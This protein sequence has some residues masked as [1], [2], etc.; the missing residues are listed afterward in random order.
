MITVTLEENEALEQIQI[1]IDT[2]LKHVKTAHEIERFIQKYNQTFEVVD[3][4]NVSQLIPFREIV[5]FEKGTNKK[6]FLI[7]NP[8][9]YMDTQ[10]TLKEIAIQIECIPF[11]VQIN[12]Q[13]F[14]NMYFI[15]SFKTLHNTRIEIKMQ[16]DER[17]IIN[18]SYL[19]TFTEKFKIL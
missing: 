11:F 19:K 14:I 15:Q 2:P 7:K 6:A 12:R 5:S 1:A 16:N 17:H 9:K 4:T 13:T 8:A 10:L 3:S 18:R